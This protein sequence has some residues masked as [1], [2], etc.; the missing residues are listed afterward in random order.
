LGVKESPEVVAVMKQSCWIFNVF[1]DRMIIVQIA[2]LPAFPLLLFALMAILK[3]VARFRQILRSEQDTYLPQN[4][5]R[6]LLWRSVIKPEVF[7]IFLE[8]ELS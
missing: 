8:R 6:F 5:Y 4:E 7:L 2:A 3:N 1:V